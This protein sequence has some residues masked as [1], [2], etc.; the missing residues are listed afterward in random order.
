MRFLV[1]LSCLLC[2]LCAGAVNP[3]EV[4]VVANA[5]D[6]ASLAIARYYMAQRQIP[7]ENLIELETAK[8]EAITGGEFVNTIFNPLLNKLVEKQWINAVLATEFDPVGRQK[9]IFMGHRIGYLVLCRLPFQVKEYSE[10]AQRAYPVEVTGAMANPQASVDSELALLTVKDA[11]LPGPLNNPLYQQLKPDFERRNAIIRVARLDGPGEDAVKRL[12]DSA[13]VG[14]QQ[15]LKGRAYIDKG[16][17][18]A[19]GE[20]WLDRTTQQIQDL[21]FPVSI[22]TAKERFPWTARMDAPALYFGWWTHQPDGPFEDNS[23]RFPP[24]ALAIHISS[25]SGQHLRN[26]GYR[27]TGALVQ[28]GV[29]GTVG[30]VYEPYLELTNKPH[31]FL[32]GLLS[33]MSA[34]E[35]Y[36][37]SMR[38]L[39][40]M[41]LYVG[42]PL[43][44][45]FKVTLDEQLDDLEAADPLDQYVLLREAS[46]IAE[47]QGKDAAFDYLR[48]NYHRAPGLALAFAIA[49][50]WVDRND[51]AKAKE[52]LAFVADIPAFAPEEMGLAFQISELLIE[53][54]DRDSAY[55]IVKTLAN[56]APTDAARKVFMGSAIPLAK[57]LGDRDQ[58]KEW[59]AALNAIK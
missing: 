46:R 18:H 29:A 34:G 26:P 24:G 23:F 20:E 48:G 52:E 57:Q 8:G 49:Q 41:N 22:D 11:P 19:D 54:G 51:R 10:Q 13:I 43:Y 27:W 32:E 4:V 1:S 15:G 33:G 14:E 6:P 44:Q 36:Y 40:W 31:M 58:V 50:G 39:S 30:N 28:R 21:H 56:Q 7:A 9:M 16:G 53:A 17:P 37:Y 25:F 42:D 59:E 2:A 45:P 47:E 5:N 55:Q 38:G 35:A 12:I 3:K